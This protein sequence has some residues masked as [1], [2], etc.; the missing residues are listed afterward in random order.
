MPND[1]NFQ[2]QRCLP[3]DVG[4]LSVLA[5]QTFSDTFAGTCSE[6]DMEDFLKTYYDEEALLA[7]LNAPRDYTF[8]LKNFDEVLGYIRFVASSMP[9]PRDVPGMAL[10]LNRLYIDK[11]HFGKGLGQKLLDFYFE[12]AAKNGFEFL[13]LGVW[14]FNFSAQ[15]FYTKNGFAFNGF[16]HPFPIGNTP[17]TDQWWTRKAPHV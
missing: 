15:K 3:E 17:Q 6:T 1:T 16:S 7:T 4:A 14:E 5:K 8:L 12:F 11:D 9:F 10:E 2:I 13:W